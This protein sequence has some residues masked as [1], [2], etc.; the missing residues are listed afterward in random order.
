MFKTKPKRVPIPHKA[1]PAKLSRLMVAA[2]SA[3]AP[4]SKTRGRIHAGATVFPCAIGAASISH[5]KRE[6]DR[7]TPA[8]HFRLIEGFFKPGA[9]RPRT[10]L[11]LRPLD[12]TLGWCEDPASP[13]YN[14]LVRLPSHSGHETMWREDGLY[15]IVVVLDYNMHPRRRY[16]GSAIFL[17]C[18][19]PD[20]SPTAGCVALRAAD[21]RK[22]L[23]RL[24]RDAKLI[25]R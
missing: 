14:R 7:A 25:V 6:G 3:H 20:F 12:R 5:H 17:H 9:G 19:R 2:A 8:G 10:L 15:D 24:A 16:L 21:L 23:P 13:S 11:P 18:A 22:L 1:G 4:S